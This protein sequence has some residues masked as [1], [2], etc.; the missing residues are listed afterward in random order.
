MLLLMT[1]TVLPAADAPGGDAWKIPAAKKDFHVFLL[2]GQSNM[3]GAG[4][5]QPEDRQPVPGVLFI[6]PQESVWKPAAHPLHGSGFGW[7]CLSS[8]R[9]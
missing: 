9:T 2:M 4:R 6:P 5:V 7:D 3:T 1:G 8:G